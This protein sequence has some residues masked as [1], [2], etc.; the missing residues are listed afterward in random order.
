VND[1]VLKGF[2]HNLSKSALSEIHHYLQDARF[3][4]ASRMLRGCKLDP[5]L[6]NALVERWRRETRTFYLPCGK[7]TITLEDVALQLNL[8][9]DGLVVTR[10]VVILGKEDLYEAFLGKLSTLVVAMGVVAATIFTSPS[11]HSLYIPIGDK[12]EPWAELCETVGPTKRYLTVARSTLESRES[13]TGSLC[14]GG[15]ARIRSSDAIVR[16]YIDIWDRKKDFIP[17]REPFFTPETVTSSEYMTWFRLAGKLY[18]LLVEA[19]SRQFHL[20]RQRRLL[21]NHR[22]EASAPTGLSSTLTQQWVWMSTPHLDQF[23]PY[24]LIPFTKPMYFTQ[25]PHYT[26][27]QHPTSTPLQ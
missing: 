14:D 27:P 10:P 22:S 20:R 26:P 19:R 5:T 21:Q 1:R 16:E 8:P 9:V 24:I 23:P 7:R 11:G 3:L 18:L 17:T 13:A 2:I 25:A 6:I 12:V 15:D 4:H